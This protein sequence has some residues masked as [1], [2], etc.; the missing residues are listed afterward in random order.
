MPHGILD[1]YRPPDGVFDEMKADDGTVRPHWQTLAAG[2]AR[3]GE[4]GLDERQESVRTL[5]REHGVTYNVNAD[6][7]SAERS[8]ELGTLPLVISAEEWAR[9]EPG[10][11]QRTNLLNL[12]LT[13]IYGPQHLLRAGCAVACAPP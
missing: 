3:L 5:L 7:R 8:W 10:L 12:V 4:D 11:I 13:D 1:G 9:L 6:G 2:L